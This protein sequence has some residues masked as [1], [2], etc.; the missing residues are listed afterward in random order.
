MKIGLAWLSLLALTA[1]L[2]WASTWLSPP[3]PARLVLLGAGYQANLAVPQNVYGWQA[4]TD[5]ADL[6]RSD[7]VFSFWGAQLLNLPHGPLEVWSNTAWDRGL[8]D[9]PERSVVLY[10]TLHGATD[11]SGPFL[12]T[13]DVDGAGDAK[14]R[15]RLTTVLDRLAKLPPQKQKVLLLDS[16]Q[17][18]ANWRLGVLA[19]NFAAQLKEIEPRI[20]AVPNLVV[21]CASDEGQRSW[22]CDEWRRTIYSHYVI[23]GLKGAASDMENDGRINAWELHRFVQAN[24]SGWVQANRAASQT[25]LLLPAGEEGRRRASRIDLAVARRN[26]QPPSPHAV[27]EFQMPADLAQAWQRHQHLAQQSP[28]PAAY[29]PQ[30]WR[31]YQDT[32]LR[33]EQLVLAGDRD[34]AARLEGQL[35]ELATRIERARTLDLSSLSNT[36]T[37]PAAAGC[38]APW[39]A[40]EVER[41]ASELWNAP[42]P[43]AAQK[44][45]AA[46]A[47]LASDDITR[48][49]LRLKVSDWLLERAAE[50]PDTHLESAARLLNVVGDPLRPRP[51]EAHYAVMLRRDLPPGNI[52]SEYTEL[53]RAALTVRRLAEQAALAVHAEGHPYSEFLWDVIA[54][55]IES[56]DANRRAGE[57]LLLASPREWPQARQQLEAARAGYL[58]VLDTGR[59]IQSALQT[60]DDVLCML[61]YYSRCIAHW[62]ESPA[63]AAASVENRNGGK[64]TTL[65]S[66]RDDEFVS[67]LIQLWRDTH[68]LCARLDD[69]GPEQVNRAARSGTDEEAM[70]REALPVFPQWRNLAEQAALVR[71]SYDDARSRLCGWWQELSSAEVPSVWHEADAA[72]LVPHRD[73][74]LRMKLVLNKRRTSR[75]LFIE[76][77]HHTWRKAAGS[78][79]GDSAA[80]EGMVQKPVPPASARRQGE[81]ALAVLGQ[82]WFDACQVTPKET[83]EQVRHRLDVYQV[84]EQWQASLAR[85]GY[86]ISQRWRLLPIAINKLVADANNAERAEALRLLEQADRLTRLVDGPEAQALTGDPVTT[87]RRLRM[88]DLLL[89]QAQRTLA[90]RWYSE[91]PQVEPYFRLAGAT[92]LNDAQQLDAHVKAVAA[93][94]QKYSEAKPLTLTGCE[95]LRLTTQLRQELVY[96]LEGGSLLAAGF[97]VVWVAPS[98]DLE[99][100]A[101]APGQ[102]QVRQVGADRAASII[103]CTLGRSSQQKSEL[104]LPRTPAVETTSLA[105]RG[106][107]RGQQLAINTPVEL[108]AMADITAT[109]LPLPQRGS[110]AV[111]ADPRLQEQFGQSSGA[112]AV[113]LDCSGSMGPPRGESFGKSTKFAEATTALRQV[114]SRLPRGTMVSVWAFGQAVGSQKTADPPESTIRRIQEPLLWNGND[115]TQLDQVMARLE[116]PA[117]EPWNESPIVRAILAAK[118]DLAGT[119]GYRTLLVLTDGMDNRYEKSASKG[120]K[121]DIATALRSAFDG[122]GIAVNIVGFKVVQ[123]EAVHAQRQFSVVES[124]DPPGKFVTVDQADSLAS[125]LDAALQQRLRYKIETYDNLPLADLPPAGLDISTTGSGDRWFPG[126]LKPGN[127]RLRVAGDRA[128]VDATINRGDLLLLQLG[129]SAGRLRFSRL[130]WSQQDFSWKPHAENAAWRLSLMQNQRTP[131]GDLRLLVSLERLAGEDSLEQLRPREAWLEVDTRQSSANIIARWRPVVGYPAA[132]WGAELPAWPQAADGISP[133][134]PRVRIWFNAE[135]ETPAASTLRRHHDF[136]ALSDLTGRTIRVSG[137]DARIEAV[138][139]ER[140]LVETRPG[141]REPQSC[142]VVRIGHSPEKPLWARVRGVHAVGQEHRYYPSI[143]SY[144]GLFWPVTSD[145]AELALANISL[146]SLSDFKQ[147]AQSRG[148]QLELNDLPPPAADDFPPRAPLE[149]P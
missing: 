76:T 10:F 67:L 65:N 122:T 105:V 145:E 32:L 75:R 78:R 35:Q 94:R 57:D 48:Q 27:P 55:Q 143:G 54:P 6:T 92:W 3:R 102:R 114:L 52:S 2:T 129:E 51:A 88:Q 141:V 77:A 33:Y 72:L 126:G 45:L 74:Q 28:P 56:A 46:Q 8:A 93:V 132:V 60:R 107:F 95:R 142:L 42:Q 12:F 4:L 128:A 20:L 70:L 25:P 96:R 125:A 146:I 5:L 63:N 69:L 9:V 124:F 18:M 86:Q 130:N 82:R 36:L 23:E 16:T 123:E 29:T 109:V 138:V 26:Y 136:T 97:P 40:E 81:M 34:W 19:N 148:C 100:E 121:P 115:G 73:P 22:V 39:S 98:T 17:M 117:L 134:R 144:S 101:P 116:Y 43:E 113:V 38:Q 91:D 87:C 50:D 49:L 7:D 103:T 62:L 111:R 85:A 1:M 68:E 137:D 133:A 30:I 83:F 118:A 64:T 11:E 84:E 31:I 44:W 139:V 140:H 120:D 80:S 106:L 79:S 59:Q 89:W 37:M 135:Q 131:A 71:R 99:I 108:Y 127:Y 21:L 24:V 147:T 41:A 149:L 47:R 90:D 104:N 61:P 14:H 119:T 112:V 15:L 110:L 13:A 53:L 66:E 58:A